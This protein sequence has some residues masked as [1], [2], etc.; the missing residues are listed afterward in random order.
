MREL[1]AEPK[2]LYQEILA[3]NRVLDNLSLFTVE[4]FMNGRDEQLIYCGVGN[5]AWRLTG[6]ANTKNLVSGN[7][8]VGH[9]MAS[10]LFAQTYDAAPHQ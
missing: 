8:T 2:V 6:P 1:A 9:V 4:A 5:I 3:A 10:T 7:G